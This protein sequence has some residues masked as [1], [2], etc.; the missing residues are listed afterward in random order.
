LKQKACADTSP[1]WSRL[2]V[3]AGFGVM[4]RFP[5]TSKEQAAEL[6]SRF[7]LFKEADA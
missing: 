4:A 5:T 7:P 2:A 3:V 6:A 1:F